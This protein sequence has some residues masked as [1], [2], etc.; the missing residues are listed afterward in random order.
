MYM[1]S[2][3][4]TVVNFLV[5]KLLIFDT[6]DSGEDILYTKKE[7]VYT[8]FF[9]ARFAAVSRTSLREGGEIATGRVCLPAIPP[10]GRGNT[11]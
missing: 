9:F 3:A 2:F 10:P 4:Y 7:G 8:F 6:Y 1:L 5:S 11:A